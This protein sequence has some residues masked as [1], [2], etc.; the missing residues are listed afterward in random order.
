MS[1]A[2]IQKNS[3]GP[4]RGEIAYKIQNLYGF[5]GDSGIQRRFGGASL[6]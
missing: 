6:H 3:R 5:I 4:Q 2:N 1:A